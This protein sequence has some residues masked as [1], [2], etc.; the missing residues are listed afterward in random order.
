MTSSI[1]I[2]RT[3]FKLL[4][5]F[6]L[7]LWTTHYHPLHNQSSWHL[8]NLMLNAVWVAAWWLI[9]EQ[10]LQTNSKLQVSQLLNQA[11][12]QILALFF[13][14][15]LYHHKINQEECLWRVCLSLPT[16]LVLPNQHR[17]QPQRHVLASWT[18]NAQLEVA[19]WWLI[20]GQQMKINWKL[21][22][23]CIKRERC[24]Q[25]LI[26][27]FYLTKWKQSVYHKQFLCLD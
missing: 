24:A 8:A 22:V 5:L 1:F 17:Q 15:H 4:V 10:Y 2:N 3:L 7:S 18:L 25:K 11:C 14:F 6:I 26:S 20:L 9:L 19:A 16:A 21:R 27:S 23:W 12:V 13:L